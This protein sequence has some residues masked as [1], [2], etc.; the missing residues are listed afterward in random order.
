MDKRVKRGARVGDQDSELRLRVVKA[1]PG[2][3]WRW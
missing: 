2:E 3:R 1:V